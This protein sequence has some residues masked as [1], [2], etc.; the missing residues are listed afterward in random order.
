MKRLLVILAV[1][2][3]IAAGLFFNSKTVK[4]IGERLLIGDCREK[5]SCELKLI[6]VDG[7]ELPFQNKYGF[8]LEKSEKNILF[9][10][11][12]TKLFYLDN[13]G[14]TGILDLKSNSEQRINLEKNTKLLN[15]VKDGFWVEELDKIKLISFDDKEKFSFNKNLITKPFPSYIPF[16]DFDLKLS[17][18]YQNGNVLAL[19]S[20]TIEGADFNT[21]WLI[22]PDKKAKKLFDLPLNAGG[23]DFDYIDFFN[24]QEALLIATDGKFYK[25][26]TT[27]ERILLTDGY[28]YSDVLLSPDDTVIFYSRLGGF[29]QDN[30]AGLFSFNLKSNTKKQLI[31]GN[32]YNDMEQ[33][34]HSYSPKFL[35]PSGKYLALID[36]IVSSKKTTEYIPSIFS[37]SNQSLNKVGNS[38]NMSLPRRETKIFGWILLRN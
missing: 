32:N 9:S 23:E 15:S 34:F 30:N 27:N 14:K 17:N 8:D 31:K 5:N 37:L 18:I 26:T 36:S 10:Q 21:A 19:A 16:F 28:H 25:L 33:S 24:N 6:S 4:K 29:A 11:D 20:K 12:G 1:T 35:S 38:F 7:K 13:T 22:S 3:I 2:L